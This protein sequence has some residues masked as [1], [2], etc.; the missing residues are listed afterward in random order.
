M[1]RCFEKKENNTLFSRTDG[2]GDGC[3]ISGVC[4]KVGAVFVS[5]RKGAEL[6]AM[7]EINPTRNKSTTRVKEID[8]LIF[9]SKN[10]NP[11]IY[12]VDL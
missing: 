9:L 1:D 10:N 8:A 7:T 11:T 2:V 6:G 3:T 12:Y 5:V 4:V